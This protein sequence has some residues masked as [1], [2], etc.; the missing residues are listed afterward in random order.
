MKIRVVKAVV[1]P[2]LLFGAE[3]Y[4]MNKKIT[5]TIQRSL[6]AALRPI[7]GV[8]SKDNVTNVAL[9]RELAVPPIC[10]SAAARRARALRKCPALK[11][12]VGQLVLH[13]LKDTRWTWTTGGERWLNRYV[14]KL[15]AALPTG[16]QYTAIMQQPR[17]WTR[18]PVP[19]MCELLSD[20]VWFRE[21]KVVREMQRRG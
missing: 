14:P 16:Q 20:I 5:S 6:N 1:V 17:G 10:A 11:T 2:R 15:A 19:A 4:G 9:W 8:S 7:A 18:S 13:P 12:W 21:E 3:V